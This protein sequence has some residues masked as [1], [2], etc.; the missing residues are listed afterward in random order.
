MHWQTDSLPLS[1]HGSSSNKVLNCDPFNCSP[2]G[3][4]EL[5][6]TATEQHNSNIL[7]RSL[8]KKNFILFLKNAKIDTHIY[9]NT[10]I[11]LLL[12]NKGVNLQKL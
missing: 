1:H 7:T 12:S 10:N 3:H 6:M 5:D 8:G 11:S 2:S 9:L 4:K